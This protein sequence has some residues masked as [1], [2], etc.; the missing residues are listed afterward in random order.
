[1]GVSSIT[2]HCKCHNTH[3]LFTIIMCYF[4]LVCRDHTEN[5]CAFT[6]CEECAFR[7]APFALRCGDKNARVQIFLIIIIIIKIQTKK[8]QNTNKK[9][10]EFL[11]IVV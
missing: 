3:I 4:I 10:F 1:M 7:Y 5:I 2:G 9:Q 11:E 8:S 6:M